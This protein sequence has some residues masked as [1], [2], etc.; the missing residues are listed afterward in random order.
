[1]IDPHPPE[2]KT[3]RFY[4]GR[5]KTV[6]RRRSLKNKNAYWSAYLVGDKDLLGFDTMALSDDYRRL[7]E[8]QRKALDLQPGDRFLDLGGG[9]GNFIEHVLQSGGPLPARIVLADLI[10]EALLRAYRKLPPAPP[11]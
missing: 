4:A 6:S 3:S 9:T 5:K 11:P 8:D 10:P 2:K 7:M 1:M